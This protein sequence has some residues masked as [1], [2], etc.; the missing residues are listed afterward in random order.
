[1]LLLSASEAPSLLSTSQMSCFRG[2]PS[3]S[4]VCNAR[5]SVRCASCLFNSFLHRQACYMAG[6]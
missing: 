3:K 4:A 6:T 1:M 2:S 5:S